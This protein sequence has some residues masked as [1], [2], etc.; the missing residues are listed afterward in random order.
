VRRP[1]LV[2]WLS[3]AL[4]MRHPRVE[5]V[6]ACPNN[7]RIFSQFVLFLLV[8]A[9]PLPPHHYCCCE[10]TLNTT[11]SELWPHVCDAFHTLKSESPPFLFFNR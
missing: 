5:Q 7:G 4:E 3:F 9:P 8:L 1:V 2:L 6:Q 10:N 11:L